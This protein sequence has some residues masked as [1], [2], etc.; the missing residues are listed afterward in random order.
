MKVVTRY[1]ERNQD[2]VDELFYNSCKD[3]ELPATKIFSFLQQVFSF[4]NI[5]LKK[6][7]K[8]FFKEDNN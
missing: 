8:D 6:D 3:E 2:K 1:L 4:G 7:G 5:S